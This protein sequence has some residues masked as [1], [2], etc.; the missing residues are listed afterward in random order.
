MST[1]AQWRLELLGPGRLADP[2]G[3]PAQTG[4]K[5]LILLAYLALEGPTSRARLS[6]LL[7]PHAP[8]STARN[9][10]AQLFRRA[11]Q[12][13]ET[14]LVHGTDVLELSPH[15][16]VDT[17]ELSAAYF[18]GHYVESLIRAGPLLAEVATPDLPEV[19]EWLEAHRL[20]LDGYRTAMLRREAERQDSAGNYARAA[21]LVEE[22]LRLD[23]LSEAA[24][25]HL[26]RLRYLQG[27]PDGALQ[28]FDA[29]RAVLA[30]QL[31]TTPLPETCALANEIARGR[32][33]ALTRK[34][35]D[36]APRTL[37][38]PELVGRQACWERMEAAWQ[39]GKLILLSGPPGVGK[40]RLALEFAASKGQVLHVAARPGDTVTP[41]ATN[42]RMARAHLALKP[43]VDLPAWVRQ[44]L[45]Q[46]LPELR[47]GPARTAPHSLHDQPKLFD[48]QLELVR[49]TSADLAAIIVDDLQY[50]D[51]AS[52]ALGS[53]MISKAY[54]LHTQDGVPPHL[55]VYRS[56]ELTPERTAV[57][58]RLIAAGIAVQIDV[59]PL[60]PG[61]VEAM[62]R[63]LGIADPEAIAPRLA[64]FTGGNPQ[65]LLETVRHLSQL[66]ELPAL[67]ERLPLPPAAQEMLTRR[68]ER[69]SPTALQLARAAAVLQNDFTADLLAD[70]LGMPLFDALTA[71]EELQNA[72][73]LSGSQF[74]HDLMLEAVRTSIPDGIRRLLSRSA[75]RALERHGGQPSRIAALWMEGGDPATASAWF[76]RAGSEAAEAFLLREAAHFYAQAAEARDAANPAGPRHQGLAH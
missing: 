68:L 36:P 47:S 56:G 33:D 66:G 35:E 53:Y 12:Q 73:V 60:T 40:T 31:Q 64:Q 16:T 11:R 2:T 62:L 24:Y 61:D 26:M 22:R 34:Q 29:C 13:L 18:Q 74:A 9:N 46:H 59:S 14:E 17:H 71:W 38:S 23:P 5:L 25:R 43:D 20:R 76:V 48:A 4:S 44:A 28:A 30:Q 63:H 52:I 39:A 15:L 27:D 58:T 3:Q 55:A 70:L 49:L 42:T 37:P 67:P 7:W 50:F 65:L 41:Y 45:A 69:L 10:L 21:Q 6:Y 75:A 57:L 8:E 51:D 1:S 32:P 72:H 54:P 19:T